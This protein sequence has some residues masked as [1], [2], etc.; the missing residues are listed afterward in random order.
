MK[1]LERKVKWWGRLS[2]LTTAFLFAFSFP[3]YQVPEF[4]YF[5]AVPFLVWSYYCEN[6]KALLW[7]ALGAGWIGCLLTLFF[8]RHV[9]FGFP[10]IAGAYGGLYIGSW[11]F[12]ASIVFKEAIRRSAVIRLMMLLGLAG[13]WVIFEWIRGWLLSGFPWLPLAASQWQK[14]VLL[15]ILSWTG[16]YGLSF[17]LI[18]FNLA[19]TSF[20][21]NLIRSVTKSQTS[22]ARIRFVNCAEIYVAIG[23]FVITIFLFLRELRKKESQEFAFN[24]GMVQTNIAPQLKWDTNFFLENLR[25]LRDETIK[26]KPLNPDFIIWPESAIPVALNEEANILSWI[27]SLASE[28]GVPMLVGALSKDEKANWFNAIFEIHPETGLIPLHYAKQKRVPF[29]EYVPLRKWLPLV[30]KVVPTDFDICVGCYKEPLMVQA[31]GK[32]WKIGCLVCYEDIFAY[33]AR[34]SVARGAEFLLVVTN[35][36]WYGGEGGAYQHASNSVLRAVECRRPVMRCGND[37]W[38]GWIDEYGNIRGVLVNQTG[39]IYTRGGAVFPIYRDRSLVDKKTFYVRY[40]DWFV[41]VC[42]LLSVIAGIY[43]WRKNEI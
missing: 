30:N 18:F 37:G 16:V 5:F 31:H 36:A 29:G 20:I 28:M 22:Q 10:F 8:L 38:S 40:G 14:P 25:V 27:E 1:K 34:D 39:T 3:C 21:I 42:S 19:I 17:V 9:W 23:F 41:I 24:V 13:L 32:D 12:I 11:L 4:S 33:L 6:K 15:Q 26:L 2:Y 43:F 35:D 7:S